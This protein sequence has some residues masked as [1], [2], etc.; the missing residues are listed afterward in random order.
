MHRPAVMQLTCVGN[1]DSL[2]LDRAGRLL[3][4]CLGSF[5]TCS[6]PE[7]LNPACLQIV[8][9]SPGK[10][11]SWQT[12]SGRLMVQTQAV[13]WQVETCMVLAIAG[14]VPPDVGGFA[15]A[16]RGGPAES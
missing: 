9:M 2:W 3:L 14:S 12:K 1:Q 15:S 16:G 10:T 5:L 7:M 6:M 8:W 13:E 4:C 11:N